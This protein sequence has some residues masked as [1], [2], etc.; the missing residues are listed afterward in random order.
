MCHREEH[1]LRLS[2]NQWINRIDRIAS[3]TCTKICR[4]LL[5]SAQSSSQFTIFKFDI[6]GCNHMHGY[7]NVHYLQYWLNTSSP[8]HL[9]EG[10]PEQS[11]CLSLDF[12]CWLKLMSLRV[13]SSDFALG[14]V[15]GIL[16]GLVGGV[17]LR[18]VGYI[19][20]GL[21]GRVCLVGWVGLGH[22]G[23]VCLGLV[24][25]MPADNS[26]GFNAGNKQKPKTSL[27]KL[28]NETP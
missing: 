1:V 2:C 23:G 6:Q 8:S 4:F 17:W 25:L 12:L 7:P 11:K 26:E 16:L 14:W 28:Q 15:G 24:P 9:K 22:S 19:L 20:L 10:W 13:G 5:S 21:S 3:C 27:N 18:L